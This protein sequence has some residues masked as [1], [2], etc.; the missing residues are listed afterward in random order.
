[1]IRDEQAFLKK[2]LELSTE[3]GKIDESSYSNAL[4]RM[5]R[6]KQIHEKEL[7]KIYSNVNKFLRENKKLD[8]PDDS[9]V[10]DSPRENHQYA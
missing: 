9:E 3:R 5:L 2:I 6:Q 1:M 8:V 7:D 10:E 4:R